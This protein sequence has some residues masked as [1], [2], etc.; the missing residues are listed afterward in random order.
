MPQA[1]ATTG[2]RLRRPTAHSVPMTKPS[3]VATIESWIVSHAP[4]RKSGHRSRT[5]AKSSLMLTGR[6]AIRQRLGDGSRS[7]LIRHP[8]IDP[9]QRLIAVAALAMGACVD[10]LTR[11][12]PDRRQRHR[13]ALRQFLDE[14]QILEH[15]V[16]AET[17]LGIPRD[18]R[19]A[20]LVQ[21]P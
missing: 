7:A 2:I 11:Y 21:H 14:T 18:H 5:T 4:S 10:I 13:E 19:R 9:E 1:R 12:Q 17:G 20:E 16:D 8:V 15:E 3:I 6:P